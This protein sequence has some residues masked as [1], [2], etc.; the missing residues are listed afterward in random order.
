MLGLDTGGETTS[1]YSLFARKFPDIVKEFGKKDSKMV[2][3]IGR[4]QQVDSILLPQVEL[5]FAG[6][7]TLLKPAHILQDGSDQ[8]CQDGTVGMDLLRQGHRTTIDFG[9]MTLT[10]Q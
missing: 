10:M 8:G 3:M 2:E 6:F 7:S 9:S 4:D 5:R 1:L